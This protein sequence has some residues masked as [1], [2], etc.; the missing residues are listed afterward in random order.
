LMTFTT[1]QARG[2]NAAMLLLR[3]LLAKDGLLGKSGGFMFIEARG[4]KT[5][6]QQRWESLL[7]RLK[8]VFKQ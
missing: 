4:K 8:A 5:R 2:F 7:R 6:K 3:D 1:E